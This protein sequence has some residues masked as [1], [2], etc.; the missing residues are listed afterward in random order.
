MNKTQIRRRFKR[1]VPSELGAAVAEIEEIARALELTP[2][3]LMEACGYD[4]SYYRL[5]R[6]APQLPVKILWAV[7]GYYAWQCGKPFM[8]EPPA[9][10]L[11]APV[12]ASPVLA[13][14]VPASCATPP[15]AL[16]DEQVR[17]LMRY[18]IQQ[19]PPDAGLLVA[20]AGLLIADRGAA[21]AVIAG[22]GPD[23]A[24]WLA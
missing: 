22:E 21:P 11:A 18:C 3:E 10:A 16:G 14:P 1:I 2:P 17:A 23:G 12:P 19:T 20:L 9:L 5:I 24:K 4:R 7:R 8:A 13:A 15:A 6:T